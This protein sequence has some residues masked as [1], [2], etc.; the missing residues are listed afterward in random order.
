MDNGLQSQEHLNIFGNISGAEFRSR[1]T[2]NIREI[3]VW[4]VSFYDPTT[5][6]FVD[7][8]SA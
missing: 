8:E 5:T 4:V 6:G 3:I 2:N 7:V 1:N